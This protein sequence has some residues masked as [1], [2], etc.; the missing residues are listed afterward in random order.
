MY[1]QAATGL[2]I[3]FYTDICEIQEKNLKRYLAIFLSTLLLVFLVNA[4]VIGNTLATA[5]ISSNNVITH[6]LAHKPSK[7]NNPMPSGHVC[8]SSRRNKST[9][10]CNSIVAHT[11][12]APLTVAA[13]APGNSAPYTPVN[14][15]NAY[16]LPYYSSPS[17]S[18]PTIAIVDAYDDPTAEFDMQVYR[19]VLGIPSCTTANGCFKKVNGAGN[20]APLPATNA[21]WSMEI[22]LDLDMVSAICYNC[23]ILL[24]EAASTSTTDLGNAVNTAVRLGATIVSNSYG[25]NG[26]LTNEATLCNTYYNHNNVAIT[27]SSGDSGPG[28]EFPAVCPNVIA[29]GGTT[30]NSNGTETA[31]GGAGGGCS[32]YIPKPFW[33][34]LTNTNCATRAVT[35]VSAVANPNTGVYV[36]YKGNWYEVGGTSA[37]APLIAAVYALAGNASSVTTPAMLPWLIDNESIK[38][39][40]DIPNA[41]VE[42]N[43]QTG[44]GSPNNVI[45][46]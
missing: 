6:A 21:S 27:V 31:W 36:Y 1:Y 4:L 40:N 42:Y 9:V 18:V 26:E 17:K 11:V 15:H 28:V 14:L 46:F 10:A 16:N 43:F 24:I 12:A 7:W 25:T 5:S 39:I 32:F 2:T 19:L 41:S 29:V 30:L 45:C 33:Q 22:S 20:A 38:C 13:G 8:H 37:S 44:L 35:D 23:H 34:N 3:L